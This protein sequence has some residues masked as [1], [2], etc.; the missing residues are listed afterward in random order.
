MSFLGV[1]TSLTGRRWIGPDVELTRAAEL[2]VQRAGLPD[3][4]C[5][6]LA[7]RGVLDTEAAGF[8]APALRDKRRE[9]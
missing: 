5:Q 3:P 4:V 1:E 9:R 2:L 8:L 7:R 6:V